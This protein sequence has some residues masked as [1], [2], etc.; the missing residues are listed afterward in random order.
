MTKL[1]AYS[2]NLEWRP[3]QHEGLSHVT[4][5]VIEM[6]ESGGE[7]H[8]VG[9]VRGRDETEY[10]VG[11]LEESGEYFFRI[12]A[13]NVSGIGPPL[14]TDSITAS[15]QIEAYSKRRSGSAL[16]RF[17]RDE[18]EGYR[19]SNRRSVA[20]R[21]SDA[22]NE[23]Y[24]LAPSRLSSPFSSRYS[25]NSTPPAPQQPLTVSKYLKNSMIVKWRAP[26]ITDV[27]QLPLLGY[28]VEVK[29]MGRDK[30]VKEGVVD[31]VTFSYVLQNL[32]S[33]KKYQVRV[34]A[35]NNAGDGE[36]ATKQEYVSV[37]HKSSN[38]PAPPTDLKIVRMTSNDVTLKWRAPLDDGGCAVEKYVVLKKSRL[39]EI[40]EE[41]TWSEGCSCV[42]AALKAGS[43]YYFAVFATN[44]NGRSDQIE[45]TLP[46]QMQRASLLT[47]RPPLSSSSSSSFNFDIKNIG[48]LKI[49]SFTHDSVS[50]SWTPYP[51]SNDI[52]APD[53]VTGYKIEMRETGTLAWKHAGNVDANDSE[54][55]AR[56]LC[57]GTDYQF[58]VLAENILGV[59][60]PPVLLETPFAPKK[61]NGWIFLMFCLF[62]VSFSFFVFQLF[63]ILSYP[64]SYYIKFLSVNIN[65]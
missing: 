45:T 32:T 37:S 52:T 13:E 48:P 47:G 27:K 8:K 29:E 65:I 51:G 41:A 57:E 53:Y 61:I 33:D 49:T 12:S 26:L 1:S 60:S 62:C 43:S 19:Y 10:T 42:V 36:A 20:D 50:L 38:T 16:K 55:V 7:W 59:S 44:S 11:G 23:A 21:S 17:S 54:F 30:W 25:S 22:G 39:N 14:Q 15:R 35:R 9:Y 63:S 34:R 3:P 46:M 4:A 58:R 31:G 18:E 2:V 56:G 28:S 5:Y 6:C 64:I 40:W 24:F